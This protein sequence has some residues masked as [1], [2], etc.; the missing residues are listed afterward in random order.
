RLYHDFGEGVQ[1]GERGERAQGRGGWPIVPAAGEQSCASAPP[2]RGPDLTPRRRAATGGDAGGPAA[3]AG[4]RRARPRG[5]LCRGRRGAGARSCGRDDGGLGHQGCAVARAARRGGAR[6][7]GAG[8]RAG[9]PPRGPLRGALCGRLAASAAEA[10]ACAAAGGGVAGGAAE[11]G[12]GRAARGLAGARA[13]ARGPHCGHGG[14]GAEASG[15]RGGPCG[16][17]PSARRAA[18]RGDCSPGDSRRGLRRPARWVR[19]L[20]GL[21]DIRSR[22]PSS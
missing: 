8:Q 14:G 5:G 12:A 20:D 19:A 3:A 18:G 13:R 21:V 10:R 9:Q 17:R 2:A 15:A 7:V 1:R 22:A 16:G 6:P 11:R 4:G